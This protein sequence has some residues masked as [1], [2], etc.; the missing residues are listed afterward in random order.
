MLVVL[1]LAVKLSATLDTHLAK[2]LH[3]FFFFV[4][5]ESVL[6]ALRREMTFLIT[7]VALVVRGDALKTQRS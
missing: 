2:V 5:L 7:N 1:V 4:F 6:R 3:F